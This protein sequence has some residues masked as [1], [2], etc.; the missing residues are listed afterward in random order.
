[1]SDE[2]RRTTRDLRAAVI[3]GIIAATLEFAAL[4]YFFR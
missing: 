2:Q 3:F 1:M 4:L